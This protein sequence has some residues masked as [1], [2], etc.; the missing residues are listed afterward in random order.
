MN[1]KLEGFAEEVQ[2]VPKVFLNEYGFRVTEVR[3]L[4][5]ANIPVW[6]CKDEYLIS[7]SS[8]EEVEM[9]V[10]SES[11][12]SFRSKYSATSCSRGSSKWSASSPSSGCR[13]SSWS[14]STRT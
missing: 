8:K 13:S 4:A 9:T 7:K 5:N 10:S 12:D 1:K 2:F 11:A 6:E 3:V 14:T